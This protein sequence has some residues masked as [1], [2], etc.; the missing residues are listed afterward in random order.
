VRVGEKLDDERSDDAKHEGGQ[1]HDQSCGHACTVQRKGD[2]AI[3]PLDDDP[4][5]SRGHPVPL[6]SGQL[7][8]HA[9]KRSFSRLPNES[10]RLVLAHRA[11]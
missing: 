10:H 4:S 2:S 7:N 5:N 8:G 11:S 3:Q 6:A 1:D 9:P